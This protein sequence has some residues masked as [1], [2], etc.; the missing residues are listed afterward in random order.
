[1]NEVYLDLLF[2]LASILASGGLC[3]RRPWSAPSRQPLHSEHPNEKH[4]IWRE[5][6]LGGVSFLAGFAWPVQLGDPVDADLGDGLLHGHGLVRAAS[7]FCVL[8]RANFALDISVGAFAAAAA[9]S[10]ERPNATQRCQDTSDLYSPD[11]GSFQFRLV[12]SDR[13]VNGAC[14]RGG[15][16]RL[17]QEIHESDSIIENMIVFSFL[18]PNSLG[19]TLSSERSRSQE[20]QR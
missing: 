2:S 4:Q 8:A 20:C 11:S 15:L 18:L 12:A 3:S 14:G 10:P 19:G 17:C 5:P 7:I 13:T 6:A 16:Q 1:M 9:Y